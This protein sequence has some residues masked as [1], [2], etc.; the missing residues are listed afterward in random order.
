MS[1]VNLKDA[2]SHMR[3]AA[4][5]KP[6]DLQHWRDGTTVF[7]KD[8][9]EVVVKTP[10]YYS[11]IG[12]TLIQNAFPYLNSEQREFLVTHMTPKEQKDV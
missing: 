3:E 4:G 6:Y 10:D 1:K 12:G 11:W 8:G 7:S 9:Y 2:L 5:I